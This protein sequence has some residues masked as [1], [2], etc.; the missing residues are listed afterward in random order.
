MLRQPEIQN[1][2]RQRL[3]GGLNAAQG[4]MGSPP[5]VMMGTDLA[6]GNFGYHLGTRLPEVAELPLARPVGNWLTNV[7]YHPGRAI[8]GGTALG[9][10]VGAGFGAMTR[11]DPLH[12]ALL[13]AVLGGAGSGVASGL[14]HLLNP[15]VK[16]AFYAQDENSNPLQ[17]IQAQL[18]GDRGM[19]SAEKA[20]LMQSVGQLSPAQLQTLTQ[21]LRTGVGASVGLLIARYL[22]RLGFTGSLLLALA[23][24]ALG[25]RMGRS[26]ANAFGDRPD[27]EFNPFGQRRLLF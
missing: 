25:S 4:D 7:A 8:L 27:R 3:S 19:G 2:I 12:T 13:G 9:G 26:P 18:F 5:D 20:S 1:W 17:F 22:L 23:G 21:M 14:T 15:P 6:R 10:L 11:R 16:R 24:G